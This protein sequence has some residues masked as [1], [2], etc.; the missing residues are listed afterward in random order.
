MRMGLYD[1][2]KQAITEERPV[3]LATVIAVA[4]DG[5]T[6]GAK[7]LVWPDGSSEGSLGLQAL[8]AQVQASAVSLLESAATRTVEIALPGETERVV[9]VFIES[10]VPAPTLYMV[11][12]V[13][14][15]SAL[16][17]LAK[18]LGFRTVVIDARAAFATDERF[19]HAD[20]LIVAWPDEA[21]A[22]KLTHSSYVAV[23]THD[24]KLDD[25]ALKVALPS[26]ARYVGALGSP[27]T[28]AK[29]LVRLRAEGLSEEHL[30]RLHAPIGLKIGAK[31]PDEIA[32][33]ILAEIV[34]AKRA[35]SQ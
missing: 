6:V 10:F 34:Q 33:S 27:T 29:R 17:A 15:A 8:D 13:H 21:L 26:P 25:P 1:T 32:V 28:H 3:A 14:I 11:G 24:P 18:V 12:A 30:A 31:T 5:V 4:G 23:L 7:L 2:L 19:S 35:K 22:G 16:T 20:E 9:S